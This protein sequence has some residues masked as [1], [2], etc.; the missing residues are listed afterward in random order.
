MAT[1]KHAS[2]QLPVLYCTHS[3]VNTG[4]L[5]QSPCCEGGG[6]H[7]LA[8]QLDALLFGTTLSRQ[9]TGTISLELRQNQHMLKPARLLVNS[10][11]LSCLLQLGI[12]PAQ[13]PGLSIETN[14]PFSLTSFALSLLLVFRT[15]TSYERWAEARE[16][17]GGVTNRSRDI[18]RQV[19]HQINPF[20]MSSSHDKE[21]ALTIDGH[22]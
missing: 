6:S 13:A 1:C 16:I 5:Y 7:N 12:L 3:F 20:R 9:G 4:S 11:A 15:N 22:T 21:A 14:A 8:L 18:L 17:W 10:H 2:K 19:R